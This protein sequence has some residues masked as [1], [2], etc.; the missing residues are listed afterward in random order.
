MPRFSF[1]E[2]EEILLPGLNVH[3]VLPPVPGVILPSL[4]IQL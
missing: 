1:P 4:A 2:Q 3:A